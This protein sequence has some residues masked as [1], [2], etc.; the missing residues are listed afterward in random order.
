MTENADK[1]VKDS[2]D[3]DRVMRGSRG[4]RYRWKLAE[5]LPFNRWDPQMKRYDE[6]V[7][8]A[9]HFLEL[10]NHSP[11]GVKQAHAL[12]PLIKAALALD[13]DAVKV[14]K[15]KI[16]VFGD[17]D[18]AEIARRVGVDAAVVSTWEALFY[19]ARKSRDA[20][21]WVVTHI[22]NPELAAGNVD[23][24]T[25][26]RLVAAV[27][28]RGAIAI[29]D[30]GSRAPITAGE[31]LFQRKLNLHLKYDRA[32]TMTEGPKHDFRFVRLYPNLKVQ[33]NRLEILEKGLTEKCNEALRKHELAHIRAQAALE[34]EKGRAARESRKAEELA[35]RREGQKYACELES[36]RKKAL[37][38]AE[39]N[40][41]EARAA[42]S[43]LAR[44]YWTKADGSMVKPPT[45][46]MEPERET[47]LPTAAPVNVPFMIVVPWSVGS[48][49]ATQPI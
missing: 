20:F 46:P 49:G 28:P 31:K 24:V 11:V 41:A 2:I 6:H 43:P 15:L 29:L 5:E 13:E 25:K 37:D 34:R 19:D 33:E 1:V 40:E 16:C 3:Y 45:L 14:A 47:V 9:H 39:R 21:G 8:N 7:Q 38:L 4:P 12:Y 42:T 26:L 32:M 36:A 18:P 48:M 27:G 17:L 23:L 10:V 30:A 35:L 22:I 44:L